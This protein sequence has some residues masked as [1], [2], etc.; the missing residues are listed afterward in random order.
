MQYRCAKFIATRSLQSAGERNVKHK[1]DTVPDWAIKLL[2]QL[3]NTKKAW[4]LLLG[5]ICMVWIWPSAI[6]LAT[7]RRMAPELAGTFTVLFSLCFGIVFA[8][9]VIFISAKVSKLYVQRTKKLEIAQENRKIIENFRLAIPELPRDQLIILLALK[10]Q[11]KKLN[12]KSGGV[13]W[14]E[15]SGYIEKQVL[16]ESDNYIYLINANVKVELEAYLKLKHE[17]KQ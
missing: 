11:E 3:V 9:A 10:D 14:L 13:F 5:I 17:Q 6:E 15:K 1:G 12:S 2:H 8:E 4:Q 7:S 16:L